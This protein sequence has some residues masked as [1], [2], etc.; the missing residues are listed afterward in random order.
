MG[1]NK[2]VKPTLVQKKLISAAGLVVRNWLVLRETDEELRIVNRTSGRFKSI[3]KS[4]APG[5]RRGLT[6]K[7]KEII[8]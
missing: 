1:K 7:S 3:K 5:S 6:N 2:V 4:P 8:S